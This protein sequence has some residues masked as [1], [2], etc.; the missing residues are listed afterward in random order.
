M[1][2]MQDPSE[3]LSAFMMRQLR[4]IMSIKWFDKITNEEILRRADLIFSLKGT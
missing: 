3:K 1:D 4:G 2:D